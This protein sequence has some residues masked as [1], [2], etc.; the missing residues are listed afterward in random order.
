MSDLP[1]LP[2]VYEVI[3]SLPSKNSLEIDGISSNLL[4]AVSVKISDSCIFN[5]SLQHG[6]LTYKFKNVV[7]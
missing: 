7:G 1:I 2:H 3:K 4:K 6:T 5:L